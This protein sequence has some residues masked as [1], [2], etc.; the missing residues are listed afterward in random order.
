[1]KILVD[2]PVEPTV[3]AVLQKSGR[4]EIDCIIP[5]VEAA[6]SQDAARIC[7]VDRKSVV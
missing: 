6:R 7:D 2:V 1:M 4:Y 5:P 3:L